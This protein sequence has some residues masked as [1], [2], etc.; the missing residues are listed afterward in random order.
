MRALR[1]ARANAGRRVVHASNM[2]RSGS[3]TV[4]SD[5]RTHAAPRKDPLMNLTIW[6]HRNPFN[7]ELTRLREEMDRTIDR[8]MGT[9]F[10][11]P[12]A[13]RLEGWAPLVDVSETDGEVLVRAEVPGIEASDLDVSISGNS[14]SITGSK[15][16]EKEKSGEDFYQCER[17]FGAF[18]RL[19]ELP[20]SIDP[21]KVTADTEAGVVTVRIGKRSGVKA[22]HVPI[23]ASN[24]RRTGAL[25]G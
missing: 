20:E 15:K 8:L 22:R 2:F 24:G 25:V 18:R 14:L 19:V 3:R 5:S 16:E 13:T 1:L 9:S 12:K 10:I 17:R 11:E 4:D 21:D 23:R 7:G 6:K